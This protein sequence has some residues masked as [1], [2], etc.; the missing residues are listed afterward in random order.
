M[1]FGDNAI[2][3]IKKPIANGKLFNFSKSDFQSI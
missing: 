2:L 1:H 3:N